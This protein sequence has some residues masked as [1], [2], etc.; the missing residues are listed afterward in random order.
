MSFSRRV[1]LSFII[2]VVFVSS[3]FAVTFTDSLGRSVTVENPEKVAV[4]NSSLADAWVSAGGKAL[5]TIEEAVE[6][7][8]ADEDAEIVANS[9][10][11]RIDH[12]LLYLSSPDFI[13]GSA[14]LSSHVE[15]AR[16]FSS[17]GIP[18]ALFRMESYEEFLSVFDIFT[19]ITGRK[20]IYKKEK[21]RMDGKISS[22]I[23]KSRELSA[24]EVLFIRSGSAFSSFLAKTRENHFAAA[25]LSDLGGVNIAERDKA[26]VESISL[27]H[28]V[29]EDPDK[30][31][32]VLHGTEEASRAF[33]LSVFSS[34]VWKDLRAVRNNEFYILEKEYFHYKPCL[35]YA[36]SY[37]KMFSYLYGDQV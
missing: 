37:E 26:L 27:E 28:V 5:V 3:I 35:R 24:P 23:E 11:M 18:V 15:V 36:E 17:L 31:L 32:V 30:I 22:L 21:A 13:I 34:P 12:E 1:V 14:D 16:K 2:S 4:L 8:F 7:G 33:V 10:G 9:S 6:R 25:I 20:D 29:K 19:D